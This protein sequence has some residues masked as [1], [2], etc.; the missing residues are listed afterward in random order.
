MTRPVDDVFI[1]VTAGDLLAQRAAI[2]AR[3]PMILSKASD[4][5]SLT[6]CPS[7]DLLNPGEYAALM[8]LDSVAFLLGVD[9]RADPR[10]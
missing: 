4:H 9:P 8:D 3:Y 2:F 6:C 5:G 7:W 1:E 10:D